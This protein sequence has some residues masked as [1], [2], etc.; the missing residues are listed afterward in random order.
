MNEYLGIKINR[1]DLTITLSQPLLI[2]EIF[3]ILNLTNKNH[4][5]VMWELKTL[6]NKDNF[7]KLENTVVIIS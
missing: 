7:G 2:V 1:T 6:L 3:N 5:K 4:T